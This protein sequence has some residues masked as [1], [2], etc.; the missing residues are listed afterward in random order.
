[1]LWVNLVMDTFGAL[2]LATEPPS[3]NILDRPPYA[4]SASIVNEVMWRNIFGHA[5][6]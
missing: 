3:E 5:I 2:A 4:K 1:M 6:F